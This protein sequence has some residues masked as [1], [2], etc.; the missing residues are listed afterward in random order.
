DAHPKNPDYQF[1]LAHAHELLGGLYTAGKANADKVVPFYTK[2]IEGYSRLAEADP[3]VPAYQVSLSDA[4]NDLAAWYHRTRR[5]KDEEQSLR[6]SRDIVL[7]LPR[8][9]PENA[10]YRHRLA[11]CHNNLGLF[12]N[13]LDE[14]AKAE[15]ELREGVRLHE[16]LAAEFQDVPQY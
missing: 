9:D 10:G 8:I 16:Q 13:Q 4:H 15:P 5:P 6:A 7:R 14:W 3:E 12:H 11:V 2:A 1:G